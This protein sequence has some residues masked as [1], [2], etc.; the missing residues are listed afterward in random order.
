M[1]VR[2][3]IL[4]LLL[5][6]NAQAM[7]NKKAKPSSVES[8]LALQRIEAI[9]DMAPRIGIPASVAL[10]GR[11]TFKACESTGRNGDGPFICG[12]K[13]PCAE[14]KS[15][16]HA[17]CIPDFGGSTRYMF[18]I[19]NSDGSASKAVSRWTVRHEVMHELL[20]AYHLTGHPLKV[21]ITRMD[22]GKAQ[23]FKPGEIIGG[24]WPSAVNVLLPEGREVNVE[25]GEMCGHDEIMRGDG[26]GI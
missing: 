7:G 22:N 6:G 16:V 1:A 13:A 24:R 19:V 23:T 26:E 14:I 25:W 4:A 11:A 3:I 2:I 9:N 10:K 21:T 8:W 18:A 5:A 17:W 20:D 15:C 12:D